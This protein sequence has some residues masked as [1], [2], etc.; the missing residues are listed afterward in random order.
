MCSTAYSLV[1]SADKYGSGDV[2]VAVRQPDSSSSNSG[3][4]SSWSTGPLGGDSASN[5]NVVS[6]SDTVFLST[7]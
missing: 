1:G 6:S 2:P 4:V 5:V 3:D 7:V